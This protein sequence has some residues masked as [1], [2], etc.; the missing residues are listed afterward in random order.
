MMPKDLKVMVLNLPS[1]P[2]RDVGRDWAGGFGTIIVSLKRRKD[3]GQSR[4]PILQPFLPFFSS[5]LSE[6]GCEFKILDCQR[7]RLNQHQLLK[8][9]N[10]ESPDIVFSLI[11]LPSMKEDLAL[12]KKVKTLLPN[13]FIVGIGTTCRV[14]PSEVL[15]TGGVDVVLRNSYPYV[16]N[17]TDIIQVLQ[18]PERKLKTIHG[19]SYLENGK[20]VST[21]ES[22]DLNLDEILPPSYD[23]LELTGYGSFSDINGNRYRY[24]PIL[25]S[26]GCPY[27]C[28]YCPYRVGFGKKWSPRNP[29]DIVDEIEFLHS[30]HGI[31]GFLFR[32]Q[33]FT[34]NKK[35]AVNVCNEIIR[36]KLDIA[37]FC[38]A[39]ANE[40]SKEL[41]R[42]MKKSG[43]KQIHYGVETGD[44][45]LIKMG[46][47]GVTLENIRK[48]F[49]LTKEI[50][51]W[52]H[53]H[54][55]LGW[56]DETQ[57]TIERTFKFVQKLDPHN[58]NW[59]ILTPYPGT[60]LHEIAQGNRWIMT[61]DWSKYTSYTT[62]MRTKQLSTSQ[63]SAIALRVMRRYSKR[64]IKKTLREIFQSKAKATFL[65][66]EI[67][68]YIRLHT[69]NP[70]NI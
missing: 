53:A 34:M 37:W 40:V 14:L 70:I 66:D 23:A 15:L 10:H 36:R 17:V 6:V 44:P 24:I 30:T 64:R 52:A 51:L 9:V 41:L 25:G 22:P 63:L 26:K 46:K 27:L 5:V 61:Y 33:S 7:L 8:N 13:A 54:V 29:K 28:V 62:V 18:Q 16:S 48:A 4:S 50:G 35:H 59:N 42:K 21:P 47:P 1:P 57:E 69:Q 20:V 12:L 3:Y 60:K 55:I 56:P 68:R 11:G 39:R 67:S 19:I 58:V 45:E 32:D 43:C 2:Y 49:R 65:T 31:K 38:E